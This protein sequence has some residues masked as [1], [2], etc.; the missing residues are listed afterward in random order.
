[1]RPSPVTELL[2]QQLHREYRAAEKA[3]RC[4]DVAG[5]RPYYQH[6]HG[7]EGCHKKQYFR[8]RAA[9]LAVRADVNNPTTLGEAEQALAATVLI[10]RLSV[11]GRLKLKAPEREFRFDQRIKYSEGK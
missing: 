9:L 3:C 4:T 10:R 5:E 1:V 2:A 11:E 7:W 6:D 8:R